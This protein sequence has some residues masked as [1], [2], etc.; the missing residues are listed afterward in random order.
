MFM[1]HAI[2]YSMNTFGDGNCHL[3]LLHHLA[4]SLHTAHFTLFRKTNILGFTH[5]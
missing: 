5:L 4:Q 1:S 3:Y 2:S